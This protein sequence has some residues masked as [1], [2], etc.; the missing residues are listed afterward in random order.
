M[1]LANLIQLVGR[2]EVELVEQVEFAKI[3]EIAKLAELVWI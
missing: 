3:I 2:A 1:E